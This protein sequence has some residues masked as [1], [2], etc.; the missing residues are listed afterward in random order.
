MITC[1]IFVIR[2]SWVQPE[3]NREVLIERMNETTLNALSFYS[4][5]EYSHVDVFR[6]ADLP[7]SNLY[8]KGLDMYKQNTH[9]S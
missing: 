5:V 3:A 1:K 6:I 2:L 8:N 4:R 9:S 7:N